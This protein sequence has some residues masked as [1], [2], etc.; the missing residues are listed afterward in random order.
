MLTITHNPR[1]PELIPTRLLTAETCASA[2]LALI[3]HPALWE[4]LTTLALLLETLEARRGEHLMT[5]GHELISL[6]D[7]APTSETEAD[8]AITMLATLESA[9]RTWAIM[10]HPPAPVL[11]T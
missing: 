4:A 10:A 11:V 6:L 9:A 1:Q 3:Q 2:A 5:L 8:Q 7:S